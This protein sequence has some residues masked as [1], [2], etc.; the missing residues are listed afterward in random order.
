MNKSL[1]ALVIAALC[2]ALAVAGG[3][4]PEKVQQ[5]S[6]YIA[7]NGTLT[8]S[9]THIFYWFFEAR[10]NP[11]TAPLVLWLTGGPGCSSQLALFYENGPYKMDQNMTVTTNPYSWNNY[12]NIMYVDQPVGTGFSYADHYSDYVTD[13]TGVA[14]DMYQFLQKFFVQYPQYSKLPF[15][16]IGESYAGHYVPAIGA[17]IVEGN[18]KGGNPVLNLQGVG[19]GNGW[20]DPEIQYGSNADLLYEN[21]LL[22]EVEKLL[23]D[24]VLYPT[25]ELLIISGAW[26]LALEECNLALEGALLGAEASAGR[27]INVYDVR[28]PCEYPPLCYDFDPLS[29]FLAQDNV[30][31]S[32]GVSPKAQWTSCNK[33]VYS[34]LLDDW[35]GNFAVDVPKI[36]AANVRVLVYSGD[37]DF[38]CNYI[39]GQRWVATMDWTGKDA[40]NKAPE[41]AWNVKGKQAGTSKTAQGLTFLR[42]FEAGHMVPM[43][44]P[45]NALAMLTAFLNNKPF[46]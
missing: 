2:V 11:K 46:A 27:T 3:W 38:I 41:N 24:D 26:P 15:F 37:K 10:N 40:Y 6:G 21:G 5:Y 29:K 45:A 14:E 9:G 44:Q 19:I 18:A 35:I 22:P 34:M 1:I 31:K 33:M 39:G 12:A 13:E 17:R 7:V 30:R 43:D 28:I 16:I 25:C 4:G 36:L 42:V 20:V 23:Y 8:D 32:L